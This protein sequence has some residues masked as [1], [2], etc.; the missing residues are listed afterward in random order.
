MNNVC[1]SRAVGSPRPLG[2]TPGC[3]SHTG[4]E[5]LM[6]LWI[7]LSFA[8]LTLLACY[9]TEAMRSQGELYTCSDQRDADE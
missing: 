8:A 6:P 2:V 9:C 1:R 5:P 3:G 4:G 7:A